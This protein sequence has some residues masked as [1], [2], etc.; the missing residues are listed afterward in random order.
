MRLALVVYGILNAILY[1]SL[2]PLWDGFDEAFHYGYVQTLSRQTAL[3]VLNKTC[4]SEEIW[5]SLRIAPAGRPVKRNLPMV[6]PFDEY[7][8]LDRSSRR[9]L[10]AQLENLP[11]GSGDVNTQMLNYEAQHPPLAYA[12]LA[13]PDAVLKHLPLPLRVWCLRLICAIAAAVAAALIALRLARQLGVPAAYA[14]AAV[15]VVLSS[16]M[17]YAATAHV[18]NDWLTVPLFAVV[19]STAIELYKEPRIGSALLFALSLTAGLLTKASFLAL[20]PFAFG[21]VL[22]ASVKRKLSLRTALVIAGVVLFLAGPWYLRN[23]LLYG[24][25]SGMQETAG[26]VPI[27]SMA[28]AAWHL[29]WLTALVATARASL[30]TGNN[31]FTAYSARTTLVMLGLIA[32]G[33]VLYV[34]RWGRQTVAERITVTACFCYGAALAYTAITTFWSSR[35]A[36]ATAAPWLV[37][38][39]LIPGWCLIFLGLS[40]GGW[41]GRFARLAAVWLWA[42][43]ICSTYL[44]KLIPFYAGYPEPR[45]RLLPLLR[46]YG[47]SAGGAWDALSLTSLMPA[48]VVVPLTAGVVLCA[49]AL[50]AALSRL[51][52]RGAP[53]A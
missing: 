17:F 16:Q 18:T 35:G 29:P 27:R 19:I 24:N 44:V 38:P 25:L 51:D 46:W 1:A 45:V 15:F 40:R 48:A 53:P 13:A 52:L 8:R 30:W 12:L 3:P 34:W 42:Y 9:N 5:Q 39:L 31:S 21:L 22:A 37:Q 36:A 6:V 50:A 23:L 28:S 10:R 2:L 43:V 32:L 14:H 33:I 41:A 11:P 49:A 20:V 7:F 26:G 47:S 4:L